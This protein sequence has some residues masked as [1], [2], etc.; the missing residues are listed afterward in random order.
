[1]SSLLDARF[2]SRYSQSTFAIGVHVAGVLADADGD[3]EVVMNTNPDKGDPVTLVGWPQIAN[4]DAEGMYSIDLSSVDTQ[5]EGLYTLK[6][7]YEANGVPQIYVYDVE[8]GPSS[9]AYDGLAPAWRDVIESVWIKFA[10]LFDSPYGG[11]NLQVYFQ[12]H[13]SRNRI[14]Q[15]APTM[16]GSLN[17]WSQP[18]V[19]YVLDENFPFAK[20][21]ALATQ[22]LYIETLRHLIRSYVE[23]PELVLSTSVS[24]V[25]RRDYMQRWKEVLDDELTDFNKNRDRFRIDAMM[26]Q[27]GGSSVLISGGAYGNWGPYA[28]PGSSGMAAARGY[29]FIGR[30]H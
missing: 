11:P 24:R 7:T 29:F 2:V 5:D 13:F 8:V 14:A 20:W 3:V 26:G 25:D 10:D 16:M 30:F 28:M 6:F 9:P 19:T 22:A 18:H 17:A 4:H 12:S 27:T 15:L 21:G 1:M 23:Q